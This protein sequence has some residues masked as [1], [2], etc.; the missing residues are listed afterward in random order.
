MIDWPDDTFDAVIANDN[1]ADAE[2]AG[3]HLHFFMLPWR[4]R[5]DVGGEMQAR[6]HF[7]RLTAEQR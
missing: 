4:Y 1:A 3:D 5:P 6:A 2:Q 7:R